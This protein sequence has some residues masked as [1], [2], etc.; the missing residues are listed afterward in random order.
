MSDAEIVPA[1]RMVQERWGYTVDPHTACGFGELADGR[2]S[3]VLA[4]ASPAKFP[5]TVAAATGVEPRH[6]FL[7]ALKD[8]PLQRWPVGPDAGS[9][10]AFL[11]AHRGTA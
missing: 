9:V 2:V 8:K 4:T 5:E 6:L 3:V 11:R 7:E 1:I 10:K